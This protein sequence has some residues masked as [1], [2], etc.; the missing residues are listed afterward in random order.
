MIQSRKKR[1]VLFMPLRADVREGVRVSPDL[2]PL[3]LL[4]IAALPAQ[5]G[6]EVHIVDAMIHE[7]YRAR[8]VE[9]CDGALLFASSCILGFQVTHGAEVARAIRERFPDLPIIWGGWFPSVQP[10][11]FLR[12]GLA[13][14]VG[15]GQG[16]LTF[17]EVVQAIDNGTP[18]EDVAGLCLWRDGH[19]L[20]TA[21]RPIVGFESFPDVPWDL[22]DFEAYVNLQNNPGKSKLRHRLPDPPALHGQQLRMFSYFSSFGCP[23][24]CSFCCSPEVTGRR[25]KAMP[26][27]MLFE[28]LE[29][30]R[31]RFNFNLIRFQDAN[32]GVSEKRSNEYCESLIEVGSPYYWNATYEIETIARY[33]DASC[34]L[35]ADGHCHLVILGA[36]AGSKEQQER[37]KKKI[38]LEINLGKALGRIYDRGLTTG[39]TWIIGYPGEE[40]ESM[41]ATID[42][43]A[44]MKHRF[45]GS[46]SDIFPF[47]PIPGSE[48][49]RH[50]A[51]GARLQAPQTIEEWG[52]CL[53]YKLE[54]DD[55]H[56]PDDIVWRW[57]RYGSTSTFYDGLVTEGS[58][59]VL[60]L[61]QRISGWRLKN[62]VYTFPIEQKLFHLYVKLTG[63]TQQDHINVDRTSGV[64]PHAVQS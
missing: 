49:Y 7:D 18:L 64:T 57:R 47:R 55:I 26:G 35:L 41:L 38:D 24:P 48:D 42:M 60:R 5:E 28:R 32:F 14:A 37:I 21:H 56:L 45:P 6:Y 2:L 15:L 30:C 34:D 20:Y 3:E 25:W 40:K 63:Q 31:E 13:D 1:I 22:L 62:G 50:A 9:L 17:Y 46:A 36:E 61:M 4:Q 43:A 27:K 11:L 12:E 19:A 58:G 51:C 44:Q 54:V 10:E 16:E 53:E 59:A 23:E 33:K 39:T 29:E 52:D 8:L